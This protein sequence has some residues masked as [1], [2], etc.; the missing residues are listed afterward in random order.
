MI[1]SFVPLQ[2]QLW[3][4]QVVKSDEYREN[5]NKASA[6]KTATQWDQDNQGERQCIRSGGTTFVEP[7]T[8]GSEPAWN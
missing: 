2:P 5:G 4:E 1:E 8:Q 6:S 3:I 7:Q